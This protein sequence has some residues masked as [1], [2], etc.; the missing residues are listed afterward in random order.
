M[1][2][3]RLSNHAEYAPHCVCM[4]GW[5]THKKGVKPRPKNIGNL[6]IL[7]MVL[8]CLAINLFVV[9]T[10]FTPK[11]SDITPRNLTPYY[12]FSTNGCA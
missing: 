11:E 7:A 12:K 10:R 4:H 1:N 6:L 5:D 9:M 8:L 2:K 3:C